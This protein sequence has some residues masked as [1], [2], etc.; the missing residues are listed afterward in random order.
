MAIVLV[1]G[2][3]GFVGRQCLI[4][5]LAAGFEVY[6]LSRQ[7]P[8]VEL[9]HSHLHW[10]RADLFNPADIKALLQQVR[11]T[12]L[13]HMAWIT[14]HGYFWDAPENEEWVAA[15]KSLIQS[16]IETGGQRVVAA[17]TCAEYDWDSLSVTE[18]DCDEITT[19]CVPHTLYGQSK[20]KLWR[21]L[22]HQPVSSAWGR[23]FY[24]YGPYEAAKRLIPSLILNI[25]HNRPAPLGP[26]TDE[27]DFTDC[28]DMGAAFTA[29]LKS[30]YKGAVNVTSG[31]GTRIADI[32]RLIERLAGKKDLLRINAL[33]SRPHDP[34]RLVGK[35]IILKEKIGFQ[36]AYTLEKGLRDTI[37]WWEA[38]EKTL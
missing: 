16:F 11:P 14:T 20:L 35:N 30:P 34:P 25:I 32:A 26:G 31:Q 23:I 13:L 33:P 3:N 12:H 24:A 37:L 21:W 7:A 2:A 28:R 22:Q 10:E 5:L 15:S 19:P 4:P 38:Q 29:M 36:P 17:G 9:E 1:T 18:S 27:H 6:A 8:A